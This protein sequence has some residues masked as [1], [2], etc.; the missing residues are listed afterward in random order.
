MLGFLKKKELY[1]E[2]TS[3]TKEEA[4]LYCKGSETQLVHSV[5]ADIVKNKSVLDV[6][7]GIGLSARNFKPEQYTGIDISLELIN[8]ASNQNPN[9][10]FINV[11]TITY[12]KSY[13]D[14]KKGFDFAIAK[15]VLEHQPN[16]SYATEIYHK[17][18]E[19]A[20]TTLIAWHMIPNNK[21]KIHK[22]KGH[23]GKT[24]YQN[25][26]NKKIFESPTLN[27]KKQRV[28]NYELWTVIKV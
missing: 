1:D 2:F 5:M 12:L 11:D 10:T 18:I 16:E 7:C 27:I 23:F 26:Y 19:V 24:I 21:T 4:P 14:F 17:M 25:E 9:H 6:G 15:A 8:E 22:L 13:R 3:I 20:D 28:E